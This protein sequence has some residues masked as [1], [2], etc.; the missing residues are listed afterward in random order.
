V[1]PVQYG[2]VTARSD[3]SRER[4]PKLK[5]AVSRPVA[6]FVGKPAPARVVGFPS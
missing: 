6:R 3:V 5:V 1:V 4:L 2:K